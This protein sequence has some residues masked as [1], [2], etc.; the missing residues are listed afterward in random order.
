MAVT[1]GRT[2]W[3]TAGV[4]GAESRRRFAASPIARLATVRPDG[5]PHVVPVVFAL[6]GD[7]IYTAVDAKPKRTLQLRRLANLAAE[8]RCSLLVDHY[9]DDWSKLW[10]VRADGLAMIMESGQARD[11]LAALA[12]RY[13]QYREAPPPGPVIAVRV[14]RWSGWSARP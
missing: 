12:E 3:K 14:S 2:G 1:S 9:E 10:W 6:L 7:T 11:G 4:D 5:Q 13:A 8:P